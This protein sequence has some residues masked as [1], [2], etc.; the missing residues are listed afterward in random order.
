MEDEIKVT[1]EMAKAAVV[2]I[3]EEYDSYYIPIE[4]AADIY[5]AMERARRKAEAT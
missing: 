4:A 5:L 3:V 2:I 1:E